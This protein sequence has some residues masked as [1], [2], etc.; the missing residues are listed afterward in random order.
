MMLAESAPRRALERLERPLT[1]KQMWAVRFFLNRERGIRAGA[2][3]D[4]AID[5]KLRGRDLVKIRI[6]DLVAGHDR[7]FAGVAKIAVERIVL[8]A[9]RASRLHV[10]LEVEQPAP[11]LPFSIDLEWAQSSRILLRDLSILVFPTCQSTNIF[12]R[13]IG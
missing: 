2:L 13:R 7:T 10:R 5:S 6:R 11:T 9:F 3:F 8:S 4:L 1:Q 12:G